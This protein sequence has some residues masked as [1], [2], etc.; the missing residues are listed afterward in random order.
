MKPQ[1]VDDRNIL[2]YVS[3]YNNRSITELKSIQPRWAYGDNFD[4]LSSEDAETYD[5]LSTGLDSI[6]IEMVDVQ[7]ELNEY[8]KNKKLQTRPVTR[9]SRGRGTSGAQYQQ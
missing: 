9:A 1:K 6:H 2:D 8:G 4:K 3:L 5:S 7:N